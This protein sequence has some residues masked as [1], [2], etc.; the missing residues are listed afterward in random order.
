MYTNDNRA[1]QF[2]DMIKNQPNPQELVINMLKQNSQQNP[3]FNNII[4]LVEAGN[5][6]GVEDIVRNIAFERGIDFDK[7]F[8]SFKRMFKR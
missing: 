2:I 4:N 8:N 5:T 7:E 3:I 6:K 1:F